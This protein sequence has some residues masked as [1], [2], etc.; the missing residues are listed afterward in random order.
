MIMTIYAISYNVF[1][2]CEA[3]EGG[4]GEVKRSR[5]ARVICRCR[6]LLSNVF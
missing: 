5:K 1:G 6:H 3:T 4:F 2:L